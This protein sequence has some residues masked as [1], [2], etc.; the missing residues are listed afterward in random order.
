VALMMRALGWLFGLLGFLM[1]V[2]YG[3][4]W[5]WLKPEV[6]VPLHVV[7]G[8]G[9]ALVGLWLFLDWGS[10]SNLG[11]DQTV[12]RSA[13][14]SFA[15][16]LAL[17]IAVAANVVG[18]K[19]DKR[20]DLTATKRYTL[21][22]QS[23][24]IAKSL[25]REIELMAFFPAGSPEE[26][27][28]RDLV[29]RYQEHTSLVKAEFHDPFSSPQLAEQM[30]ILSTTGTAILRV[31][32]NEQRL[33]SS[34]DEEALTNA[35]VKVTSD[36]QHPVCLVTGHGEL[37]K[38]DAQ[39]VQGLGFA[40]TK[41]EGQNYTVSTVSLLQETPSP[42]KCK[43]VVLAG[44][45]QEL[46]AGE[47]DR[48]AQYVAAG[49]GLIVMLDPLQ[50]PETAADMSRYG[51]KVGSDVVIEANPYLQVQ[52][53]PFYVIVEESGF[54]PHPVTE[55]L[56]GGAA[57]VAL[58]RSVDKGADVPG[59]NVQ[60]IVRASEESWGETNATDQTNPAQ[61]DPGVD[62]V[63]RVPL[64]VAVE[65]TDPAA[66]R[67]KTEAAAVPTPEGA[68]AVAVATPTEPASL[69]AKAG[70][71][72][73]VFGDAD[74]VSNQWITAARN[75]DLFLNPVAWMVGE[76]NQIS[77]RSNEAG[78]GKLT[79]DLVSLF[80][81]AMATLLVAPGLAIAGAVGTWLMRRKL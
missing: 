5:V 65:V 25:D 8:L 76:E 74:F 40:V 81:T 71:K 36:V 21:S 33:E 54:D 22:Q 11:K 66:V 59:L 75:Q 62:L 4:A 77:I 50:V 1:L 57:I 79:L 39:S 51:V 24:D 64:A 23:V 46:L 70:G 34:F 60:P 72:V 42:E 73:V 55:K 80:V 58:A 53:Q 2:I 30:K 13:T 31:G 69:P 35:I 41:I 6:P 48:L 15:V 56:R 47:R 32:E 28:F 52:G 43:V 44:P 20:W 49:G 27:N 10:L 18:Q 78:K 68:P 63:G 45:Q 26:S 61:P 67:T 12:L 16:L 7:G 19:Y 14:A 9:A 3:L 37:E 29:E 38:D 17:G